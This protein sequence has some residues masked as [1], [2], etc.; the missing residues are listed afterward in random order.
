MSNSPNSTASSERNALPG[1]RVEISLVIPAYN[2]ESGI[3]A[4]VRGADSVLRDLVGS[5][6]IVVVE[7]G[8]KDATARILKQLQSSIPALRVILLRQNSGQHIASFIGL[9]EALGEIVFVADADLLKALPAIPKLYAALQSDPSL[10]IA[11]AI[12]DHKNRPLH[13]SLGSKFVG[14]LINRMTGTKLLDPASPL[15]SYRRHVIDIIADADVL[16]QN[17][18]IL[19]SMLG[20]SIVEIPVDMPDTG[21]RSRY[22]VFGLV[23]ILLLALL[24]FSSGTRTVLS[25]MA[26]GIISTVL[27]LTGLMALTIHGVVKQVALSTNMLLLFVMLTVVGLQ[28]VMMGGIAYKIERINAN[29]RFRRL[30]Y[31][32]RNEG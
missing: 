8:S 14:G 31:G 26:L 1:S 24:N 19:T 30:A 28:F 15:R 4:L 7:D 20:F 18:P 12:R 17:L 25:L 32:T 9:R 5:F 22:H 21:R 2:E 13:R 16:S 3:E 23:H 29:L 6:E 11:S 10:T 27:G